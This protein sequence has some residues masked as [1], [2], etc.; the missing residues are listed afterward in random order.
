[1]NIMDELR[2]FR[3]RIDDN[4]KATRKLIRIDDLTPEE[5][6]DIIGIYDRYEVDHL[7][8]PKDIFHYKG[9]LFEVIS[10]HTS[11]ADWVPSEV[12]ALY[13]SFMPADVID[14][15]VQPLGAHDSYNKGDKVIYKDNVYTST[16]NNNSWEPT[17]YGW[18]LHAK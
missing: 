18:E 5:I 17:V 1:M 7:Y 13:K 10:K 11:Q 15:W 14:V 16:V 3:R 8:K 4:I 6:Q 2:D 12:P 9:E